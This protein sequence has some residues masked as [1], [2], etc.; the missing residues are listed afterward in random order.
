MCG[1]V[2]THAYGPAAPRAN[3]S[4]LAPACDRMRCRGPDAH[5]HWA[6]EDG[7]IALAHQ[8]LA[9]IDL[10]ESA[11]QPMHDAESRCTIVFNGEIYNYRE[12]RSRLAARGHRFRTA[13]DTEVLL[14]LYAEAGAGMV[15]DLRGMFSFAI[16]D[17]RRHGLLLARDHFGIK[18]LY[19]ADDGRSFRFA[20]EVRALLALGVEAQRD[21]AGHAGFFLWGHVPEPYT[22][23]RGIRSLPAG[24]TMWVGYD[25]AHTPTRYA[26]IPDL[27]HDAEGSRPLT[28]RPSAEIGE[29]LR[30]SLLDTVSAHMVS[31]VEVGVFLSAGLDS[32][33][34][35]TLA[36]EI[37]GRIRTVTLG[38]EQFRGTRHDETVWAE[39]TARR[40]GTDHTTVWITRDDFIR[41]RERLFE[42]MDQPTT[43]G[44]NTYF[45]S[46]A[47]AAA[48]LKVVLS[49]VGGDELF[50]G[51]PSFHELPRLVASVRRV[52]VSP[53]V[54]TAL[55][56]MSAPLMRRI[57][58]P[59]YASVLEYGNELAGAYLL[60]RA[61]F[62][63]WE[64]A[65]E[66]EPEIALAGLAELD[67]VER[68]RATL[69][70]LGSDRLKVSA[71]ESTWYMRN[72]L[73][74]DTDW[75]SMSHSV[76]VRTPL[77]DW[78][79][80]REIAPL[81]AAEPSIDK[82]AMAAAAGLPDELTRRRKTGFSIP[83]RSW[84]YQ[85]GEPAP[86][87]LRGWAREVY[88]LTARA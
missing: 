18:P 88:A 39:Q 79:L 56:A 19:Y 3:A 5:G 60:R 46:R 28:R 14:K 49:G 21:P 6:S 54:A 29:R 84:L 58:S 87:G 52:P 69:N 43:D 20:S 67:T 37:G 59:K 74:R 8:R 44:V 73:L 38:F 57:A 9:I 55:R 65:A 27:L 17:P 76:E 33:T 81:L 50:G 30:A 36:S 53:R 31:D 13:S 75:T 42:R 45:V 80:W 71:L 70:A 83:V 24:S 11:A 15:R 47:A 62:L 32:T 66:L 68:L 78:T 26:S 25:G 51:Y 35:A 64:V 4:S 86:R 10:S 85:D 12:L 23:W 2:G 72:Q 48:G 22:M 63:P 41:E 40:L 16:W 34:I 1:I 7:C 61:M 77:V 82:R